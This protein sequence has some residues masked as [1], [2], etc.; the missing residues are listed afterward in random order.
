MPER[1][2]PP[3]GWPQSGRAFNHGVVA[4]EGR[5]LHMT[6]QV[7]L[8]RRGRRIGGN[9]CEARIHQCFAN[10]EHILNAVGG[11]LDDIVSL[12][13]CFLRRDDLHAIQKVRA[14]KFV[15]ELAPASVL[16]Q[17]P[18]LVT[19]DLRV[20]LVPVAVIPL[21]RYRDPS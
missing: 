3:T 8:D 1:F 13:I 7:A 10:V 18:G 9:D 20:E 15:P 6:G 11:R 16:I 4:P 21:E 14:E 12:T 5:T 2:N 19:P 17:V